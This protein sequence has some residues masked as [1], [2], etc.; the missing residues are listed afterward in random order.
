MTETNASYNVEPPPGP[1]LFPACVEGRHGDCS[2]W[3]YRTPQGEVAVCLCRCHLEGPPICRSCRTRGLADLMWLERHGVA[4]GEPEHGPEYSHWL[5]QRCAHCGGG[6]VWWCSHNCF[7]AP[8]DPNDPWDLERWYMLAPDD[9]TRLGK[10]I[11]EGCPRPFEPGCRCE[12]HVALR[13][14]CAALPH[15]GGEGPGKR[16]HQIT[17][18]PPSEPVR[19]VSVS[20]GDRG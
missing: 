2:P 6:E 7:G 5:L 14:S 16:L 15:S 17:L 13:A 9:V 10:L 20:T 4:P 1:N 11:R 18:S 3:H 19:F 8:N 12:L